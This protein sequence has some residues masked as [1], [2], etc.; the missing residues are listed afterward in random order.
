MTLRNIV[1]SAEIPDLAKKD[2]LN[3]EANGTK[4]YETFVQDRL[5]QGSKLTIWDSIKLSKYKTMSTW[6]KKTKVR[7]G[8]KVIML[9]EERQL[10]ARLM[11]ISKLGS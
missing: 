10:L 1:S 9:R 7:V 6:M 5:K 4:L 2:I 11:M 3:I 8:D